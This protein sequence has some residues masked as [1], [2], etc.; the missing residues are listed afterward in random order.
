MPTLLGVDL[1]TSSFKVS[2]YRETGEYLGTVSRSTPW[3]A[4]ASGPEL[5]PE[6]LANTVGR[7]VEDCTLAYASDVVAGIGVTGMA[8][9]IFVETDDRVVHPARAWNQR[10]GR[11]SLPGQEL[12][13][14]TGLLD[15]RRSP[16][17]ELRRIKDAGHRVRAWSGLPEYAVQALGGSFVA[18]RSLASRSG[19]IDVRAGSWSTPLLEWAG[20][21]DVELPPLRAAGMSAGVAVAGRCAGAALTV[22]GHDHLTAALGAG[23][24]DNAVFDSFG[25]GEGIVARIARSPAALVGGRFESLTT[26]GFNVGLGVDAMDVIV[27]AGLGSGNRLNLLL[28]ALAAHGFDREDVMW[29]RGRPPGAPE[30]IGAPLSTRLADLVEALGG[31]DWQQLHGEAG[32]IVGRDVRDLATARALWWA[33]IA[34]LTYNAREVLDSVRRLIPGVTRL[35]AAGGWYG[36]AG[37]RE[38]REQILGSFELPPVAEAGTRGAALLA[39]IAADVYA[40]RSDFP[41]LASAG[42]PV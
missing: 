18:E 1:G 39:G 2:A 9:T 6:D 8:E 27:M 10:L 3:R 25:T 5:A 17:V 26:A 35:V 21:A 30:G 13:A 22:A 4:T 23:A 37:I 7:L 42:E 19:L 38:L 36:N 31:P 40:K 34:R 15:V 12:F 14:Q 29:P 24:D 32:Q 28:A 20:V 33:V 41:P 16:A 11:P